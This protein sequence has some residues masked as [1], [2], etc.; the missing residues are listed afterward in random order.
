MKIIKEFFKC[1]AMVFGYREDEH[2]FCDHDWQDFGHGSLI[3]K[4]RKCGDT[5]INR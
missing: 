1:I 2:W 3:V 4:C 5:H